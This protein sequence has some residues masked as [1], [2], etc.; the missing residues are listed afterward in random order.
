MRTVQV[1]AHLIVHIVICYPCFL[2][3]FFTCFLLF[4]VALHLFSFGKFS[5]LNSL[6]FLECN[7]ED[8]LT[9]LLA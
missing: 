8:L 5:D 6:Q 1:S 2:L 9:I 7:R 3:L 4:I